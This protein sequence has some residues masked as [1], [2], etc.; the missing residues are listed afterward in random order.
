[1]NI[2]IAILE[3]NCT[4]CENL[5]SLIKS[6]ASEKGHILQIHSFSNGYD[7]LESDIINDCQLLFSDIELVTEDE[8]KDYSNGISVCEALRERGYEGEIIFLTAFREYVFDGYN[9]HA[10]NY[11]LKPISTEA[12]TKCLDRFISLHFSDFYYFHK[13]NEIIQIPFNNILTISRSGHECIIQTASGVYVERTALKSF[14]NRL[15]KQFIRCHKSCIVNLHHIVSM[16]GY[17]IKLSNKTTQIAG[18]NYL[19]SIRQALIKLSEESL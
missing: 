3:D 9:V 10:M 1:M 15:P 6:W 18:R 12:V 7:I 2:C 14:E 16:S 13:D 17:T 5:I 4:D 11:L 19:D 8:K